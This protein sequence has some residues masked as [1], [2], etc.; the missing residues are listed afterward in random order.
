[1]IEIQNDKQKIKKMTLNLFEIW[2]LV[3]V[4]WNLFIIWYLDFVILN[5]KLNGKS[6]QI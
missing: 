4:I 6:T 3:I 2:N 5:T 1:M